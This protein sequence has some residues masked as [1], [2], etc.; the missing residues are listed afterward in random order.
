MQTRASQEFHRLMTDRLERLSL[1]GRRAL[2]QGLEEFASLRK[3][4]G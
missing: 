3:F 2:L 1:D 4:D